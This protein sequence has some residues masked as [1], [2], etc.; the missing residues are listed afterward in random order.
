MS[1]EKQLSLPPPPRALYNLFIYEHSP[2]DSL[3]DIM[4]LGPFYLMNIA[5]K[6]QYSLIKSWDD[7]VK[8]IVLMYNSP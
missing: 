3:S 6:S 8:Y 2:L 1:Q 7:A 5:R 4:C